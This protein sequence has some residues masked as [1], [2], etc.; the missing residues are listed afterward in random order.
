MTRKLQVEKWAIATLPYVK[1]FA[2]RSNAAVEDGYAASCAG[3]FQSVIDVP[4]QDVFEAV[5]SVIHSGTGQFASTY[6]Q[7]VNE[8]N[9]RRGIAVVIQEHIEFEVSGVAFTTHPVTGDRGTIVIELVQ[10]S[11]GKVIRCHGAAVDGFSNPCPGLLTALQHLPFWNS[12]QTMVGPSQ[13]PRT[14]ARQLPL[15]T[16]PMCLV[17]PTYLTSEST[18]QL[19]DIGGW[20]RSSLHS[21]LSELSFSIH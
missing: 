13:T 16:N 20:H 5:L 1:A 8:G 2:V 11:L 17:P 12:S 9:N 21:E 14:K 15:P 3:Q 18:S 19:V 10:G 6:R 7:F 4:R